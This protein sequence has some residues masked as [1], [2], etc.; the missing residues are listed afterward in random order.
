MAHD[1]TK[2]TLTATGGGYDLTKAA[3]KAGASPVTFTKARQGGSASPSPGV[4]KATVGG[5]ATGKAMPTKA[6]KKG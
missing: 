5:D 6:K 2:A 3:Q 4:A 1:L